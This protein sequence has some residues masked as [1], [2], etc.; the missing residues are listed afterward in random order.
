VRRRFGLERIGSTWAEVD[1]DRIASNVRRLARHVGPRTELMAVVKADGYGHGAVEV[2]ETALESGASRLAVAVLDEGVELRR[3]GIDAPVLVLGHTPPELARD[4]VYWGLSQAVY[5][6]GLV[7]ALSRAAVS[8]GGQVGV[9]VKLDTGMGRLGVGTAEEAVALGRRVMELDGVYVEGVYTHFAV[10]DLADKTHTWEQFRRYERMIGEM[11]GEGIDVGLR[12][13]ANSA[14]AIS[15]PELSLDAVRVGLALYG[16]YPSPRMRETIRL[17]PAMSWKTRVVLVKR[18]PPGTPISYGHTYVTPTEK[19]IATLPVGYADGYNRLLSNRAQVLVHGTRAPVVGRVC[20]DH[21][22]VDVTHIPDV[23]QGDE[24]VL[25]GEGGAEHVPAEELARLVGTINYEI[26]ALIGRRVPR[27][28]LRDG[29]VTHIR[30][31]LRGKDVYAP[32]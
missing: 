16:L 23:C 4:V 29:R 9:H 13:V 31:L 10:A 26:V 15:L 18:L 20:M 19:M 22:M 5:D 1:L 11:E 3:A 27:A 28:Y 7:E 25:M 12:H 2:A 30:N 17:E 32:A 24:V 8:E 14:A 21:L 6:V